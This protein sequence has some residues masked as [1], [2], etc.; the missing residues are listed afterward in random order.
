MALACR[1]FGVMTSFWTI[2]VDATT[3]R[4]ALTLLGRFSRE[5]GREPRDVTVSP[6]EKTGGHKITFAVPLANESWNDA[7]VE[8]IDLG[9]R[10]GYEWQLAGSVLDDAEGRSQKSR[11]SGIEVLRWNLRK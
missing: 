6:Y 2:W 4:K 9:Q 1:M 3:E 8:L 11:V 7:V 10:I 5:I